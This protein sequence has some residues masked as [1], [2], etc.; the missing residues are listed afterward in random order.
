M[1]A[2]KWVMVRRRAGCHPLS[3]PYAPLLRNLCI[4]R[5]VWW[6]AGSG[7]VGSLTHTLTGGGVG[8]GEARELSAAKNRAGSESEP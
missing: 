3:Y 7:W 8:V 4:D 2:C 5:P 1:H 6:A